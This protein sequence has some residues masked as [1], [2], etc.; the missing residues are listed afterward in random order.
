[1]I[2][3][4]TIL[5]V[6]S[7][8]HT[9]GST[10]LFPAGGYNGKGAEDNHV[11]PNK[12]QQDIHPI[13]TRFGAEVGIARKGK[14]LIVVMLGDAIDGFHHGSLQ[15]SLFNVKDQCAAHIILMRDWMKR[16]KF[17]KG[18]ELY[19]VRGTEAHVGDHEN[20]MAME[21]GAVKS[22]SG[23][24]VFET[25]TL[26]INGC[27]NMFFHHGTTRGKGSNEGNALRNYLR[28]FRSELEKD[29]LDSVDALWT[30]HTHGPTWNTH[31]ARRKDG[32]FHVLHGFI[33]PSFQGKTRYAYGKVPATVNSV[34]G[35][36]TRVS[37][38]GEIQRP[39]FV[40]KV[41]TDQ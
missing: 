33:C 28:D 19:Y 30:G 34:G 1:M 8:M 5:A 27:R 38:D 24:H 11:T 31:I 10:A 35:V 25:L 21:L 18:D 32:Q 41:M 4:D 37:V 39:T 14:R 13:F 3:K 23:L 2:I 36:Y 17:A 22:P 15:E 7:D 16:A 29:G 6:L 20:D 9:G 26:D 12:R 40:V